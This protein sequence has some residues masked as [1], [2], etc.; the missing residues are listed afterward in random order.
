[1]DFFHRPLPDIPL[2]NDIATRYDPTSATGLRINASM[3]APT[4]FES[5]VRE[6]LDQ[7]DGWGVYMPISIPFTG[8]LDIQSILDGHR[9]VDYDTSNDVVYLIDVDPDSPD[10]G[11]LQ[12]LDVGEGNYP[13]VLE[14]PDLYW[15]NDPRGWTLSI[16]FDEAD[17]D[18]NGNGRLDPGE[19]TDADGV[20]DVPNYLPGMN[21]AREDLAARA[22]ALMS[23]Y[24]RETNTLIVRPLMPLRERTTYAVII[25][26]RLLD[27]DGNPVGSPFAF[28]NHA[29][30]TEALS[31]LLE[32]ADSGRLPTGLGIDDIAFAFTFT[33]QSLQSDWVAVR[34]GLYGYGVQSHLAEEFP[35]EIGEI[36]PLRD[37]AVF[38]D[39]TNARILYQEQWMQALRFVAMELFGIDEDSRQLQA[40][41]QAQRYIDYHIIGSYESPQLFMREDAEG[42]TL[43]Y[44]DQSWPPDLS[45]RPAPARSE[46]VYF[47]LTV[48]R[49]EISPRGNNEPAPICIL[50]H[51]YGSNRLEG[52][53][54][55][56]YFAEHGIATLSVD[57]VSHGLD[58]DEGDTE[59]VAGLIDLFGLGPFLDAMLLHRA[60][61]L[62]N[63]GS[64]DSGADFW[65]AYLFHTRDVVRQSLLDYVQFVRILRTFDGE[66]RW[67][68]DL[69]GDGEDDLAGDFD[70]DGYIDIG[71]DAVVAAAGASLGGI[72]SALLGA[73][74]PEIDV[75]VPIAGG[76]GLSD[77]GLRSI[78]GG[79]PEGVILPIMG[80]LYAGTLD[81]DTGELYIE[82]IVSDV[83][84]ARRHGIAS[85]SGVEIGDTMVL[86]NLDNDELGCG[87]IAENGTVRA[88]V[89]SDRG[90]RHR[91]DFYAGNAL[92]NG[93]VC[94]V[95]EGAQLR[96]RV[97]TIGDGFDE[98]YEFS[99][100]GEVTTAGTP[101]F[102]LNE[103]LGIERATPGLRRFLSLGQMVLDGAD[104]AV[105]ARHYMLEPLVYPHMGE[106]TSTHALIVT[107]NGDMNVPAGTGVSFG[108]A[109]GYIDFLNTDD[110]YG[111]P[112]NQVLLDTFTV[113][114]VHT[115]RRYVVANTGEG[116]HIDIE[117]FSQT[118]DLWGE[119]VPRLDPPLHLFF[120]T[121]P[122]GG[123]LGG[124]SGAIFPLPVPEGQHG[125]AFPGDM[126]DWVIRDCREACEA[127]EGCGCDD[128]QPF[129]VG[130]FMFNMLGRYMAT[131]GTELPIGLCNSS[132]DC[133]YKLPVPDE[134]PL[135]ELD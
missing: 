108:R 113:E 58:L 31:P 1:M 30:Q 101:L 100:Q 118:T 14:R 13:V 49:R 16:L 103:G 20:L 68:F 107:T 35:A 97:D 33:T 25:S 7:M 88:G 121:G 60:R 50:G 67:A 70:G 131:G 124:I 19:D 28:V 104:P 86:V 66:T 47:W 59:S 53:I 125:F 74:E 38:G 3:I 126:S 127:E 114:A 69:N 56:G 92:V 119:N 115:F 111:V 64:I 75:I 106:S 78:N 89:A 132:N 52:I 133:D 45:V 90:D 130:Y 29:A 99:Y 24:E 77:V 36:L 93:E 122:D 51:G 44:N 84:R 135:S 22:D 91:L 26:R 85:V 128:L 98:G 63:D 4:G 82:A 134:R 65:T 37:P 5:H 116:S 95:A 12:H 15:K 79:V 43:G 109:A 105:Y 72:M 39:M 123:D 73:V 18:L 34:E 6:L 23:F 48:P 80:P 27:E 2:P 102:A 10:F 8:P 11:D 87:Y 62:N 41:E 57:S 83:N 110:R 17:E 9:D 94:I 40:I 61:D 96:F 81:P 55:S 32:L 46:T 42:N 76:G 71:P 129:D 120:S 117:N 54:F 21:P 112:A